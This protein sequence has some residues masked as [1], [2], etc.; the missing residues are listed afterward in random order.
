MRVFLLKAAATVLTIGA[1]VSS[2][3]Y[4]TSHLKN[5][6]APLQPPVLTA[7]DGSSATALG[8]ALT[9]GPS[10]QP[11]NV[12]PMTST[13]A[14]CTLARTPSRPWARP[15]AWSSSANRADGC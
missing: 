9:L 11:S 13:Y 2:A 3:L 6:A 1:T 8:G 14:S 15:A 5:P 7:G 10:V 4:V 12:E